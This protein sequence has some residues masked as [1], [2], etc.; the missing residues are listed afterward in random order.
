MVTVMR[1]VRKVSAG[2]LKQVTIKGMHRLCSPNRPLITFAGWQP[3]HLTVHESKGS[4]KL[5]AAVPL[6]VKYHSMGEFI[7]DQVK[8]TTCGI[9]KTF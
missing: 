5:M 2:R 7:F 8:R 4:S 3:Q 1:K 6:Y 9:R